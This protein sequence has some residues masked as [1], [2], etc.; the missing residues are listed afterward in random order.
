MDRLV[1]AEESKLICGR[2]SGAA[3][4]EVLEMLRRISA[5]LIAPRPGDRRQSVDHCDQGGG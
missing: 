4:A 3:T 2:R 5:D 1:H